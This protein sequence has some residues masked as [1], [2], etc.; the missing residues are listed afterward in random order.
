MMLNHVQKYLSAVIIINFKKKGNFRLLVRI[1]WIV[2]KPINC[3]ILVIRIHPSLSL[4]IQQLSMMTLFCWLFSYRY[5]KEFV[6]VHDFFLGVLN[7]SWFSVGSWWTS[8][9]LSG[10]RKGIEW[11]PERMYNNRWGLYAIAMVL[12]KSNVIVVS[13]IILFVISK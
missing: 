12:W 1:M 10:F 5:I 11:F 8:F 2:D 4:G 7:F 13:M 6:F 3:L 9:L